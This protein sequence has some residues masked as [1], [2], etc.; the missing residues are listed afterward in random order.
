MTPKRL[1]VL[2]AVIADPAVERAD[3]RDLRPVQRPRRMGLAHAR[4]SGSQHLLYTG[5]SPC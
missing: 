4:L 5:S 1:F 2:N 3:E